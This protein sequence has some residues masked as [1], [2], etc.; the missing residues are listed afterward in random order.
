MKTSAPKRILSLVLALALCIGLYVPA[1]AST[2][3][4]SLPELSELTEIGSETDGNLPEAINEDFGTSDDTYND[5]DRVR[6]SI[7]LEGEGALATASEL[8]EFA[9]DRR[10]V[11]YRESLQEMQ[12]G[13]AEEISETIGEELDV[14]WNLT[15]AANIISANMNY[16]D[17]DAVKRIDGVLEVVVEQE[18]DPCVIDRDEVTDP[19]M[20]TSSEMIGSSVAWDNG[21]TGAG[22]KIAIIDT[23]LDDQHQSFDAD[24]FQYAIEEVKE[25]DKSVSLMEM[26]DTTKLKQLNSYKKYQGGKKLT[27]ED[28]YKNA[29]IPYAYNYIDNNLTTD[30]LSDTEGE[31]G[32]HVAGIAAANRYI[33]N[34]SGSYDTALSTVKTQGVAPDAQ[35]IIMKVFGKGGGAYDSDYMAAIEDAIVLGADSINLSL[36]SGHGGGS[37]STVYQELLTS[38]Q[39]QGAVISFSAGNSYSWQEYTS[40]GVLYSDNVKMQTNGTPGSYT[41]AFTVA[42]VENVGSTEN[43]MKF[44]DVSD[45]VYYMDAAEYGTKALTTLDTNGSGTQYDFILFDNIGV[46]VDEE[47]TVTENY[48]N[49]FKEII[50][51]KIV[52]VKRGTSTFV[53]KHKAAADAGAIACVV[54]NSESGSLGMNLSSPQSTIPCVS[55]SG[56]DA[57]KIIAACTSTKETKDDITYYTGKVT[58]SKQAI[59]TEGSGTYTMSDFSSWGVPGSLE[60][61]PEITAPGGN[62]YS[63][64]GTNK[65]D[66]GTSGGTDQYENMSGTSMAAPQIAGMAAV[67]AQK[68]RDDNKSYSEQRALT[69]SLLMSTATPLKDADNDNN[70]YSVMKQGA[71]LAN[72]GNALNAHSYITMADDANAGATD[73]KVKAELGD[74]PDQ[75]GVYTF[76]YTIHNLTDASATYELTTDVF[77]QKIKTETSKYQQS[78]ETLSMDTTTLADA[79]I[80]YTADGETVSTFT[81]PENG[82]VTV[83]VKIDVSSCNFDDYANGAYLE[84]FSYAKESL[85]NGDTGT[86]HS[87]PVL[88]FYGNWSDASMYDVGSY[89]EYFYNEEDRVPYAFDAHGCATNYLTTVTDGVESEFA[90]NP[91]DPKNDNYLAD[92]NAFNSNDTK[93]GKYFLTAI[94]NAA[95]TKIIV[96]KKDDPTTVYYDSGDLGSTDAAYYF[97]SSK[98][99]RNSRTSVSIGWDGTDR[100]GKKLPEGTCVTVS[101]VLAPEYYVSYDFSGTEIEKKVEW[102]KLGKGAYLST[103]LTIDNTAPVLD[104]FT[105]DETTDKLTLNVTD[106]RYVA[107]AMLAVHNKANGTLETVSEIVPQ[108]PEADKDKEIAVNLSTENSES[109]L[110]LKTDDEILVQLTDYA[111]NRST[112]KLILGQSDN[113][114]VTP[115]SMTISDENVTLYKNNSQQLSLSFTPWLADESATWTSSNT[116]VAAV[117]ETGVVTALKEGTAVIT[118]KSTKNTELTVD[119]TVTVKAANVTV[120]AGLQDESGNPQL[121]SWNLKNQKTWKK[122]AD[123]D[124]G[125]ISMTVGKQ[126]ETGKDVIYQMDSDGFLDT[127]DPSTG[128]TL[129]ESTM[130]V[131]TIPYDLAY[132]EGI[133]KKTGVDTI[134]GIYGSYILSTTST[135]EDG[136]SLW[137]LNEGTLLDKNKNENLVGITYTRTTEESDGTYDWFMCLTSQGNLLVL[138]VNE[139]DT[140]AGSRFIVGLELNFRINS[141]SYQSSLLKGEDHQLYFS[142]FNGTTNVLYL[143]KGENSQLHATRLG[144][145]GSD[146]WPCALLSVRENMASNDGGG[147][148]AEEEPATPI[149]EIFDDVSEQDWYADAVSFAYENGMMVGVSDGTFDPHSDLTRSMFVT[150]LYNLSGETSSGENDFG[151]VPE[152]AWYAKAVAWAANAGIASGH[153]NGT[154]APDDS[155][156]REQAVT[157][158]YQYAKNFGLSADAPES[159]LTPYPDQ[160]KVSDYATDA[161]RWAVNH[162]V[163]KGS[164]GKL[165]PQ[166]TATRA[167]IAAMMKNFCEHFNLAK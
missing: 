83:E 73:G 82:K 43:A 70:Y 117:D 2:E 44:A 68:W 134:F 28:L 19:N 151:D 145:T 120:T 138:A 119:C 7:V 13:A 30:H 102:E 40:P 65:T 20:A 136:L 124:Y 126:Q 144:D 42:S 146:V 47:N 141:N 157:I 115:E 63:V 132:A 98:S 94:R 149:E 53:Q 51:G 140:L 4:G 167:E 88:G 10:A 46:N 3:F 123:L 67:L 106:N 56:A 9:Q 89:I 11:A 16:G 148:V 128:E 90:G 8:T 80:T 15:L 166:G 48:L 52:L 6:V 96:T 159:A 92:R 156:T 25:G 130:S 18:Y 112:Y 50:E 164:D 61:K 131:S 66:S 84:A 104:S 161:M 111:G 143:L 34:S 129:A 39:N 163:I 57:A 101:L 147:Y 100:D 135:M 110:I 22:S 29:K 71:G 114:A 59:V 86:V 35:L 72:V 108:Q 32:S 121:V 38:L 162:G 23:G 21:Y 27:A 14:V 99:W 155:I 64:F 113:T 54:Y 58:I 5:N 33:K 49:D 165:Y 87:I 137:N 158:L 17:I 77:T 153:G 139:N 160:S 24:A 107:H 81:V 152:T 95:A 91:V 78:V 31:H 127:I 26:T 69:Q 103:T 41:N 60:L 142:S 74:D 93:L 37:V 85:A 116:S 55:I 36:G 109:D 150:I 133:S 12:E 1:G 79:V 118:A 154:F 75:S 45:N 122:S 62:I 105:Y 125:I 76:C 97:T